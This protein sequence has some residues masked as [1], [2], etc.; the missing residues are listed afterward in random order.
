[1]ASA[2][3]PAPPPA[4]PS[5]AAPAALICVCLKPVWRTDVPLRLAAAG[6]SPRA[7]EALAVTNGADLAALQLALELRAGQPGLR[8]LALTVGPPAA[9][10]VLRE[11]LAAGADEVL[12]VW[13][14]DWP[15]DEPPVDGTGGVAHALAAA[16]A[17]ALRP[18]APRLVLTGERS[19]DLGQELFG[20]FLA[21]ALGADFAHRATELRPAAAGWQ[22]TVRLERGYGQVLPLAAPALVTV[23][24]R[25]PRPPYAALPAWLASRAAPVPHAVASGP[26]PQP[27][28]TALRIPLPRVKRYRVPG[29][30]LPA[31]ARIRAMVTLEARGGGTVLA[32]E[33]PEAQAEALLRLLRERGYV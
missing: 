27:A 8:V 16:A 12:R 20:G 30:G 7:G 13:G 21:A 28:Q 4:A 6:Q 29:G 31:E 24:E 3:T 11:A 5:R 1:M 14:A 25:L 9:A 10:A 26:A 15:A 23:S 17:E 32:G 22:A 33:P 2:P 18:R 19:A